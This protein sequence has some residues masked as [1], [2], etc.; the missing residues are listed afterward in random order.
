[1]FAYGIFSARQTTKLRKG[2]ICRYLFV[3][4][5]MLVMYVIIKK[6]Y[7]IFNEC[8]FWIF[9]QY[10]FCVLYRSSQKKKIEWIFIQECV[11]SSS[12]VLCLFK[13]KEIYFIN[14]DVNIP[15]DCCKSKKPEDFVFRLKILQFVQE[16]KYLLFKKEGVSFLSVTMNSLQIF[17]DYFS[18]ILVSWHVRYLNV[19]HSL[20]CKI[21]IF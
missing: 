10:N 6:A 13:N 19:P 8:H 5:S 3:V 16:R 7:Y 15:R 1:M 18:I 17:L 12:L 9:T 20:L 14:F 2:V 21:T 4:W 11:L